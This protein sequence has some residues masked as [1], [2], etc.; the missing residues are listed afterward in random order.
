MTVHLVMHAQPLPQRRHW[1]YPPGGREGLRH[2]RRTR[3]AQ[4]GSPNGKS[5]LVKQRSKPVARMAL[6]VRPAWPQGC[7]ASRLPWPC[8]SA[9]VWIGTTPVHVPFAHRTS[10]AEGARMP[11]RTPQTDAM[12]SHGQPSLLTTCPKRRGRQ[13]FVVIEIGPVGIVR[14]CVSHCCGVRDGIA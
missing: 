11:H 2:K 6:R 7:R 14:P 1:P 4:S 13:S 10:L 9:C 5:G 3:C 12:H 8:V